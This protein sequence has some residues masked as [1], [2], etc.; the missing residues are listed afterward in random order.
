M[1]SAPKTPKVQDIPMRQP[2]LLPDNG[3]PAVRASLKGQRRLGTSA[4]I[5]AGRGGSLGSPSTSG[6]LGTSGL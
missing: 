4:M 3:D 2:L 1:C 6:P 5:F